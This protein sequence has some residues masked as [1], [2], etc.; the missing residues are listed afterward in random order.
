MINI[1]F[2]VLI[3]QEA[4]VSCSIKHSFQCHDSC[5]CQLYSSQSTD[6]RW[7]PRLASQEAQVSMLCPTSAEV[8]S[9]LRLFVSRWGRSQPSMVGPASNARADLYWA[10]ARPRVPTTANVCVRT[11]NTS[12]SGR[13]SEGGGPEHG[14]RPLLTS[15]RLLPECWMC[16]SA[17]QINQWHQLPLEWIEWQCSMPGV[18][19]LEE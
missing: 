4:K 10:P 17:W 1:N 16:W 6:K 5:R 8:G 18:S 19:S 11:L 7:E 15:W 9:L 13:S 12:V 14:M 2:V 3:V